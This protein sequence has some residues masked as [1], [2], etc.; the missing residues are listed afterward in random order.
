M[1]NTEYL[2]GL[3]RIDA[4]ERRVRQDLSPEQKSEALR[5]GSLAYASH[6]KI[7]RRVEQY[8]GIGPSGRAA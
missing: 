7:D 1:T 6:R 5:I 8:V 4:S 2:Q 3:Q